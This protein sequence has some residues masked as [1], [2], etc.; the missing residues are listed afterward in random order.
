[1]KTLLAALMVSLMSFA[2]PAMAEGGVVISQTEVESEVVRRIYLGQTRTLIG[3]NLPEGSDVRNRFEEEVLGRNAEQLR[4]HW[5][6]LQFTG[7]ATP[8]RDLDSDADVI[9][10][11]KSS[12]YAIGYISNPD[13]VTDDMHIILRF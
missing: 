10:Y 5:S 8:L 9:E 1:M 12:P 11:V 4:A 6:R 13:L 7:R 3:V 2:L